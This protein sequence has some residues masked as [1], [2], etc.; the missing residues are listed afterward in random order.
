MNKRNGRKAER[1]RWCGKARS[2]RGR[3]N[4]ESN[5]KEAVSKE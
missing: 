1:E 4:N 2:A 3:I 5:G